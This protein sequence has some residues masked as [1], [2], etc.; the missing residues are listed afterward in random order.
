MKPSLQLRVSQNLAM[1]PQLQQ[2]IRL[3][4][5][6][7]L[8]LKTEIQNALDSNMMLEMDES[9]D[10]NSSDKEAAPELDNESTELNLK[11]DYET[12]ENGEDLPVETAWDD[13]YEGYINYTGAK[14]GGNEFFEPEDV[15]EKNLSD[16]L[17]WQLNLLPL[18]D[19][20]R[21]IAATIID[22][23]NKDGYLTS[24]L[25]EIL[26]IV[27]DETDAGI[28]EIEAMLS[29]VQSMEPA[30]VGARDLKECL[31]LQL[32]QYPERTKWLKETTSL[33]NCHLDLLAT[34]D[35][36]QLMKKLAVSRAE[37]SE[38]ISLIQSLH[39]RPGS[40]VQNIPVQYVIPDIYVKKINGRWLVELNSESTP[41]LR[42]NSG[43]ADMIKRADNSPDNNSL[44]EHLQEARWLIKSLQ[45]R[46]ETLLK[47]SASIIERQK[48]FLELGDQGMKPL[49]L[50]DI[51]EELGLHESTISRVTTNKYMHT[52]RGIF[53]L[54]YFFSSHVNTNNGDAASSTAIR[55]LIK[56]LVS[57]ENPQKPFSDSKIA[58]ILAEQGINVARRT[59]AKYRE[60]LS[61]PPSNE[62]KRLI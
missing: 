13:L 15:S 5:L 27:A 30:G 14:Q 24:P 45:S 22:F 20:D 11:N 60:A 41:R 40:T 46:C 9:D 36:T 10:I 17:L 32:S 21:T 39:P 51:A 8:E 3:L 61:I 38:I 62:R 19:S 25:E 28:E 52:P 1:T 33:I 26:S 50:H 18:S 54:K 2:A 43:Y 49:V 31:G 56:K 12:I 6:S 44:K 55:A 48:A 16:H 58:T 47:V 42:I 53:E 37:L 29:M 34:H 59:I 7:S 35:Y 4:Q 23:I 57:E